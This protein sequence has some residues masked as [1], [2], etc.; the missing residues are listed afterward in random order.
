MR[1]TPQY[2]MT[3]AA[4]I[5]SLIAANPWATMVSATDDGLVASH[6]PFLLEEDDDDLV[7]VSHVGRPDEQAH[8]L[9]ESELLVVFEGPTGYISPGWY[10]AGPAVPTWNFAA[11]HAYG[12]PEI[13]GDA[14]NLAV[15]ERLVDHFE[16]ELPEPF[17]MRIDA[18]NSAYAERIVRGTV[19]FRMR[20]DRVAAKEKMSQGK[21]REVVERVVENLE[22]PGV[23]AN[24][25]L[26][27]RMRQVHG[28]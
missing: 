25:S 24:P 2:L 5:R 14:E 6:Y 26:A 20:V 23:Y 4:D 8:R 21:P 10:G 15:L 19:G 11:V 12:V 16:D 1:E 17:G 7:L 27:A 22:R 13:L 9:G 3:D 18:A 28:L